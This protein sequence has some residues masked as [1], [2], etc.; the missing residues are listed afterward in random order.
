MTDDAVAPVWIGT[1]W[2][3][4]KT[5]AEAR[6]F[7]EGLVA[8]GTAP[9]PAHPALRHSAFHGRARSEGDVEGHVG[10]G[11]R[12][13]HA[14]GRR[15]RVDRRDLA[16]DAEGLRPRP[17]RARPF[18]APR[19]F[20]R[21]R[22]DGR[23]EDRGRRA[24]R[25]DPAYLHWRDAR[26]ARERPRARRAWRRRR[27]A[28][29]H[30]ST[31]RRRARPILFAYE[32][33]WAIGVTRRSRDVRLCRRAAGRDHRGRGGRARPPR[34]LPLRRFGQSGQLR[35]ADRRARMST[36]CSSGAPRGASRVIS[37]SSRNAPPDC[38]GDEA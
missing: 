19:T 33:V 36:G 9:R 3:M 30:G 38:E 32:P 31:A 13:E 11:R 26:R 6:V 8:R 28:R 5:L 2:K 35:G 16:G 21:D 7:A 29:S 4:N 27:A 18:R 17:R 15:G 12:P 25:P 20:R 14:L 23:A 10:Q 34:S 1:S 24:P 37:T 22:R